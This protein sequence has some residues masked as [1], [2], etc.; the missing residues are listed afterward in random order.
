MYANIFELRM[1]YIVRF[2]E[3]KSIHLLL[4]IRHLENDNSSRSPHRK[5][6]F[7]I[8]HSYLNYRF[9]PFSI[10][11][12][13][14]TRKEKINCT[15]YHSDGKPETR[16]EVILQLPHEGWLFGVYSVRAE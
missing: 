4:F 12:G 3:A 11:Y 2:T 6:K 8:K 1:R 9:F 10:R 16:V 13:N 7:K 14:I 5:I 15:T